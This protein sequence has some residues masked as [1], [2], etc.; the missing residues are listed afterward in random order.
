MEDGDWSE[1]ATTSSRVDRT[2]NGLEEIENTC[3]MMAN[4]SVPPFT[5]VFNTYGEYLTNAQLLVRYGFALDGNDNDIISWGLRELLHF[6]SVIMRN[7]DEADERCCDEELSSTD[8]DIGSEI[9]KE[10][11]TNIEGAAAA[12]ASYERQDIPHY[13]LGGEAAYG[14]KGADM[15]DEDQVVKLTLGHILL[16]RLLEVVDLWT[17]GA[18]A[19]ESSMLVYLPNGQGKQCTA[20]SYGEDAD[21]RRP[22]ESNFEADFSAGDGNVEARREKT[23]FHERTKADTVVS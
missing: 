20:D 19:W 9:S 22:S 3:E 18:S 8:R 2:L 17:C 16:E 14:T 1:R 4:A 11:V 7:L 13:H 6:A 21:V 10:E 23:Y 12:A 15:N 5:E